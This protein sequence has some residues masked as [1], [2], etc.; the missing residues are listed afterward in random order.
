MMIMELQS[1]VQ[2]HF[3]ILMM[4]KKDLIHIIGMF[5]QLSDGTDHK[6]S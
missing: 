4:F 1:M 6:E 2:H 5:K 3:H